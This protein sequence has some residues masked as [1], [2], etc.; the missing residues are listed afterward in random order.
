[1]L[2]AEQIIYGIAVNQDTFNS[3]PGGFFGYI[4]KAKKT[5]ID[6]VWTRGGKPKDLTL[7]RRGV[8]ASRSKLEID[9]KKRTRYGYTL[10]PFGEDVSY[11][12]KCRVAELLLEKFGIPLV[13]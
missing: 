2:K 12:E 9:G 5:S 4:E 3:N 7:T 11:S 10:D 6:F 8:V 1:M 13:V